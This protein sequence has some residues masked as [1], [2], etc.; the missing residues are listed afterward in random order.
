MENVI[1]SIFF[2]LQDFFHFIYFLHKI[3]ENKIQILF[4]SV[5]GNYSNNSSLRNQL[6]L[7]T[8]LIFKHFH[9]KKQVQ[10]IL[11][12]S[13]KMFSAYRSIS[14]QTLESKKCF[15]QTVWIYLFYPVISVLQFSRKYF[16]F[17][18]KRLHKKN[19]Q[20]LHTD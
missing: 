6:S 13:I 19:L 16:F 20:T 8:Q 10:N 2:N 18:E 9:I 17:E 4:H 3:F 14:F 5:F 1:S 11:I 15:P 12:T 7:F